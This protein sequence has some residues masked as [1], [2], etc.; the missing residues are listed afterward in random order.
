MSS[1]ATGWL[2][3]RV[4][5]SG[6]STVMSWIAL[7]SADS[8]VLSLSRVYSMPVFTAAASNGVPSVN[9][10]P[11]CSTMWI[12]DGSTNST[13]LANPGSSAPSGPVGRSRVS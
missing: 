3:F 7:R 13:S 8:V 6:P 10:T 9:A 2:S 11:S 1:P 5:S 12:V 4:S